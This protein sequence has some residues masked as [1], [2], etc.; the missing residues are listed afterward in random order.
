MDSRLQRGEGARER[1]IPEE[2]MV[3]K[4]IVNGPPQA[5]YD[6]GVGCFYEFHTL[7]IIYPDMQV[8]GCEPCK[9]E[10]DE[11][12]PMFTGKLLNIAI[13]AKSG[14]EP[15]HVSGHGQGGSSL[16]PAIGETRPIEY[17]HVWTL[18]M[19]DKWAETP[20]KILLW[21]DIEGSELDAL[22]GGHEL[23]SSGRVEWINLET[24]DAPFAGH[25]TTK[26]ISEYLRQYNY[27]PIHR[28]N[29]QGAYPEAPG[30]TIY[31]KE[32]VVPAR[33]GSMQ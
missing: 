30:D 17:I 33:K 9:S 15:L 31:F 28:Y 26:E 7:K 13:G 8:F 22:K 21:M 18:D 20:D 14:Y 3:S 24:R 32:G 27:V 29:V 25:P 12:L 19:F 2:V 11:A 10:Y 16:F 1:R 4:F 6:I 23:L 5:M